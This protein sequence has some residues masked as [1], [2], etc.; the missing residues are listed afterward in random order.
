MLSHAILGSVLAV[1][2]LA[3]FLQLFPVAVRQWESRGSRREDVFAPLK[4]IGF[5]IALLFLAMIVFRL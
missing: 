5:G 2:G 3:S 4:P 1:L